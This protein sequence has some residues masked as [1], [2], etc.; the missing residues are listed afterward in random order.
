MAP[1]LRLHVCLTGDLVDTVKTAA[2]GVKSHSADVASWVRNSVTPTL[3]NILPASPG[4]LEEHP[5]EEPPEEPLLEPSTFAPPPSTVWEE[6]EVLE[7][8]FRAHN[9][10]TISE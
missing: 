5:G 6:T 1:C 9:L 10:Q 3:R 2:E 4:P 8:C 7:L